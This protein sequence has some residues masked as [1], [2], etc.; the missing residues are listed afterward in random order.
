M[1]LRLTCSGWLHERKLLNTLGHAG[2][3][4]MSGTCGSL[5]ACISHGQYREE[6]SVYAEVYNEYTDR[7]V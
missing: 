2:S 5:L 3:R 1:W 7:L 6:Y 4:T